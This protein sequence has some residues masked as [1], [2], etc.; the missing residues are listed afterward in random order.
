MRP[1]ESY[2]ALMIVA[3]RKKTSVPC[4]NA[5]IASD[6]RGKKEKRERERERE[7]EKKEREREKGT[8]KGRKCKEAD[9]VIDWTEGRSRNVWR[10]TFCVKSSKDSI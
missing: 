8:C 2:P 7:R 10:N 6:G 1:I 4:N 5:V 3:L 9:W